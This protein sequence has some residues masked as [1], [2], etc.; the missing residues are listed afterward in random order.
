[1]VNIE[2]LGSKSHCIHDVELNSKFCK[3]FT[4]ERRGL[5]QCLPSP[6]YKYFCPEPNLL[7][8]HTHHKVGTHQVVA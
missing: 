4:H 2:N 1:M 8:H 3:T 7:R 6:K 5:D